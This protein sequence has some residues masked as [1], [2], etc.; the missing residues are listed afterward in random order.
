MADPIEEV[1]QFWFGEL[2]AGGRAD[3]EHRSRWWKK[4]PAF[5]EMIRTRFGDER[6]AIIDGRRDDWL[7]TARGRLA[8]VITLDQLSR[9]MHRGTPDMFAADHLAAAATVDGVARGIDREYR[10][11]ERI[12]FYM[13]LM[14]AES[15]EHQD[16]CVQVF[17][18]FCGELEGDTLEHVQT[19]LKYA[20]QHRDIVVRFGRFPHRNTNLGRTSTAEEL[21]FLEQPGSSF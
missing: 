13:P 2:D 3:A 17:S 18:S 19:N 1:L 5:D 11:D 4:D 20:N 12:F 21:A 16:R 14:H 15:V 7:G 10:T 8:Y 9:N 6:V